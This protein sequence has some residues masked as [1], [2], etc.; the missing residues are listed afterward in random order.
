MQE[1]MGAF[2]Q[3]AADAGATE[4]FQSAEAPCNEYC[5][6]LFQQCDVRPSTPGSGEL[7]YIPLY[8]YLFHECIVMNGMM[9]LG[10]EPY[11][12]PM[13]NAWNCVWGEIPGAVMIGDGTLLNR[14]TFNWATWEPK[15]GSNDDSLEMIRTVTAMRRGPGRDFLVFGRMQRPALL[16][17]EIMR[18]THNENNYEVPAVAQGAWTAPDGRFGIVLANWTTETQKV[19]I[20]DTRLGDQATLHSCAAVQEQATLDVADGQ[21]D[22]SLPSMSCVLATDS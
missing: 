11:A 5:L 20:N 18:W 15:V 17:C 22:L 21:L 3:I 1:M 4:A 16:Q 13:R 2:H 14:E 9:S 7:N 19:A 6:P 8:H 10:G 12:L